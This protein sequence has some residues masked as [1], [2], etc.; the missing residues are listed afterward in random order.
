MSDMSPTQLI[1]HAERGARLRA[2]TARQAVIDRSR[3]L[4]A[5]LNRLA[6]NLERDPEAIISGSGEVQASGLHIDIACASLVENRAA[7]RT[8]QGGDPWE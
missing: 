7:L 1:D 6:D 8:L 5:R 3:Q 2:A 4:A